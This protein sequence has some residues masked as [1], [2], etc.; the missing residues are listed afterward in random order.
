MCYIKLY[1]KGYFISHPHSDHLSG[2]IINST[3]DIANNIYGFPKC[4]ETISNH[5]FNWESW[6]NFGSEGNGFL[7][8][9]YTYKPLEEGTE[10]HVDQTGM[11]IKA[12][13]LSH[14]NPYE[15]AAFLIRSDS[16]YVLYFG[17]TGPD[18]IERTDHIQR[19]WRE[20]SP[21]VKAGKLKAIFLEVS[22]PDEQLDSKLYGHLTPKWFF[23]EM[24]KLAELVGK[25]KMNGLNVV[26]THIKPV[27]SNVAKIKK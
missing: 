13:K 17:D 25:E 1:I 4:L 14:A 10:Q 22:Y 20:I 15:S 5:Y 12:F 26:V 21:L 8:K 6:P 2:L 16:S 11:S 23:Y 19:I 3:E 27:W 7:L 18:E 24:N 9:K